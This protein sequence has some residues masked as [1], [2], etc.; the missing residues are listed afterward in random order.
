[1]NGDIPLLVESARGTGRVIVSAVPLDDSNR[2]NLVEL[3]AFAPL[4]HELVAYLGSARTGES[5][6]PAGQAIRWELPKAAPDDG[7][8]VVPPEGPPRTVA[9][10]Q[11]RLTID[12]R[13]RKSVG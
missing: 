5:N 13:D 4:V 10:D 2:A 6:M 9:A 1:L 7:W 3:P 8:K 11:R 12:N